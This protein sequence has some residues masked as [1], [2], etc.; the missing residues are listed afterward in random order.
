MAFQVTVIFRGLFLWV[1]D[2]KNGLMHVLAPRTR[3]HHGGHKDHEHYAC[4]AIP[5]RYLTGSRT[6][7]TLQILIPIEGYTLRLHATG[8]GSGTATLPNNV[9]DL[10][11]LAGVGGVPRSHLDDPVGRDLAARITLASGAPGAIPAGATWNMGGLGNKEMA[12]H[13]EWELGQVAAEHLEIVLNEPGK[14]VTLPPL[15]PVDGRIE[16]QVLHVVAE[17]LPPAPPAQV[18]GPGFCAHHFGELYKLFTGPGKG[19]IPCIPP[20]PAAPAQQSGHAPEH[21]E[22]KGALGTGYT[23]MSGGGKPCDPDDP[24]NPCD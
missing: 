15:H 16:L 3:G 13:I 20:K 21:A 9:L 4:L 1:P 12:W 8:G 6:G 24:D 18:P 7:G 10:S 14:D 23:C 22:A 5:S 2:G 17:E 11:A 19:P